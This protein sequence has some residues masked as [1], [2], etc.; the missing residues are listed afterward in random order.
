MKFVKFGL[1]AIALACFGTACTSS[2]DDATNEDALPPTEE[3]MPPA[4]PDTAMA[5]VVDTTA[6]ATTTAAP[7]GQ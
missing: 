4:T 2:T 1:F 3:V 7:E 6:S 5:P